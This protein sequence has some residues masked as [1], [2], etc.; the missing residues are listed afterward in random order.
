M[1]ITEKLLIT[2]SLAHPPVEQHNAEE[3]NIT[4]EQMNNAVQAAQNAFGQTFGQQALQ[5]AETP[6]PPPPPDKKLEER[7]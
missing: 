1:C 2:I 5:E 6:P 4:P 7:P 3:A